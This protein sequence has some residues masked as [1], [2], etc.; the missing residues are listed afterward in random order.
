MT[1]ARDSA[2]SG[3]A[4][5]QKQVKNQTR[6]LL[7]AEE[8]L[9]I[10]KKQINDL[11]KKLTEAE[12]AKGVAEWARDEAVR[13]KTETEF[14]KTEAETSKDKA[15]KEVTMRGWLKPRLFLKLKSLVYAGYT[16]PRFGI[17]PSNK[18]GW[19]FRPTCG[20]R[21]RCTILWPFVRPHPPT[22]RL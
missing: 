5:A 7:A 14:A 22:Q 4:G 9:E 16:A 20:R 1:R 13:A 3:L 17:R 18:L 8:Q 19:K 6:R 11:K 2:E 10:A 12:N 21:R 15:E